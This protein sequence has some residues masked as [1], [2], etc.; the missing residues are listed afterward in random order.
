MFYRRFF[1][2]SL[3]M[4][5]YIVVCTFSVLFATHIANAQALPSHVS[6][7]Q[8]DEPAH[9]RDDQIDNNDKSD[10][11]SIHNANSSISN[12]ENADAAP[13]SSRHSIQ[14]RRAQIDQRRKRTIENREFSD[15]EKITL[16]LNA[17]CDF[18]TK[19]DLLQTS[20]NAEAH[21]LEIIEDENILLSVRMRA[22]Q[23]LSYFS[24]PT[25]RQTLENILAHP[26]D[27]EHTLMLIQAIRAYTI[28]APDAAP[29][30][31]EPFLSSDSDFIR[32]V[33]I[34]SLKNCPGNAALQVLQ[35]RY[36]NESNR[37]FKMRLKQAIDNH[38][39][40]NTYCK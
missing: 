30:A 25:N 9:S 4:R 32:F 39:K 12:G 28:I 34:N 5:L 2:R 8:N 17:H 3:L 35:N 22:V 10:K 26:N 16:L 40:S 6:N 37:F 20:I 36:E 14:H 24:T 18:P 1:N 23:A 21:L 33:T 15:K 7:A 38:C 13:N 19:E 27:V 29:K 31:V 11:S